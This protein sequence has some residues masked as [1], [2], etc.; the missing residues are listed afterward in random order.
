MLINI[1]DSQLVAQLLQKQALRPEQLYLR[2]GKRYQSN[3]RLGNEGVVALESELNKTS[4]LYLSACDLFDD[5]NCCYKVLSKVLSDEDPELFVSVVDQVA[6]RFKHMAIHHFDLGYGYLSWHTSD[7]YP[8]MHHMLVALTLARVAIQSQRFCEEEVDSFIKAAL[9]MNI[10]MLSLQA[11]LRAQVEPLSREQKEQIR[12][13]PEQ[14]AN[15][16]HLLG[17]KDDVWLEAVRSHHEL[18]DGSGYPRQIKNTNAGAVLLSVCDS[19]NA[20]MAQREYRKNF[21]AEQAVKDLF[22]QGDAMYSN[23]TAILLG[24]LGIYPAGSFVQLAGNQ[25]GC[26]LLRGQTAISPVVL[27][28]RNLA[29]GGPTAEIVDTSQEG[30][31]VR[32]A[33]PRRDLGE[34]PSLLELLS[35]VV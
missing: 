14:S 4:I 11:K 32:N 6:T 35:R 28:F 34:L 8:V 18:P 30:F 20:R 24:E 16:L 10:S 9:T 33:L 7:D 3:H 15:K 12:K 17:V 27:V 5:L 1:A 2:S 25:I 26:S 31:Q 13:H 23:F 29:K 19:F 22:D 21:T